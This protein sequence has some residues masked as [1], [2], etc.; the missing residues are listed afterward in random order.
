MNGV[1]EYSMHTTPTATTGF[2]ASFTGCHNHEADLYVA[3]LF[4][5]FCWIFT[6]VG[7]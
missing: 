4:Q 2:P 6:D 5:K 7:C 3:Y 1:T